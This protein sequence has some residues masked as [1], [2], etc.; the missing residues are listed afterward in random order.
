MCFIVLNPVSGS[1]FPAASPAML[2]SNH[3]EVCVNMVSALP[4]EET[5]IMKIPAATTLMTAYLLLL[6]ACATTNN[7]AS[8]DIPESNLVS[9]YEQTLDHYIAWVPR[10]KAQTATVA[11]ALTHISLGRAREQAGRD[12]CG[13]TRV[14]NREV[15]RHVGPFPARAPDSVGGYD[16]WYYRISHRPGLHG[17]PKKST[18]ELYQA[19]EAGLPDWI[20]LETALSGDMKKRAANTTVSLD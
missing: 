7:P 16:A 11:Q 13:G 5:A 6:Q 10:D 3:T 20:S 19:L 2:V 1:Q 18:A 17:C 9:G 4:V 8:T 12:L 15:S 14:M